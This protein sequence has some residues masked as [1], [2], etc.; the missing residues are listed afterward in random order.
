MNAATAARRLPAYDPVH[1]IGRVIAH[2]EGDGYRVDCDGFAWR[3][4]RAA[5]CLLVPQPGDVVLISGP[6]AGRVY[7]IAVLEQ[8]DAGHTR[9]EVAGDAVLAATAGSLALESAKEVA[10]QGREAVRIETGEM[11]VRARETRCVAERMRYVATELQATVGATRLV[12]KSYEAVLDRLQ[13]MSRLSFRTTEEI[14]QV[15][16]GTLDYQA[17]QAARVHAEYTLVTGG[18]LVKVDA[19]QIHMG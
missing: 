5:S 19:R 3:A 8:A 14:E 4:R 11:S 13:L 10:L 1:L 9:L 18:E 12:G 6:D 17:E 15:R 2:E 7:L 16:A